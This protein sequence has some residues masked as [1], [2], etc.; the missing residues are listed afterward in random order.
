[1]WVATVF[2]CILGAEALCYIVHRALHTNVF[3]AWTKKHMIHHLHYYPPSARMRSEEYETDSSSSRIKI[4][5][6]GLEWVI[7]TL[8]LYV[9]TYVISGSLLIPTIMLFYVYFVFDYMHTSFHVKD[10]WLAKFKY[11][12]YIRKCHDKHHN[13]MKKNFGITTLFFDKLFRTHA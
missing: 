5:G 7:P 1:M 6:I 9:L 2:L 13:N 3:P 4:G 12:R 8:L 11:F 10:H